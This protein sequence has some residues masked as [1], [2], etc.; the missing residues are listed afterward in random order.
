MIAQQLSGI[1]VNLMVHAFSLLPTGVHRESLE[2][3]MKINTRTPFASSDI[4]NVRS[5]ESIL[6]ATT[7]DQRETEEDYLKPKKRLRKIS[8][9]NSML[10]NLHPVKFHKQLSMTNQRKQRTGKPKLT[11]P[12]RL[13][14][15]SMATCKINSLRRMR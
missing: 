1:K 11:Q 7:R 6:D 9:L 13:S 4:R 14:M 8:M 3:V 15:T 5:I 10:E 12:R 2:A